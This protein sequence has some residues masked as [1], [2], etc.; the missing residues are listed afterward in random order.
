LN[1][2]EEMFVNE[3]ILQPKPTGMP[4]KTET[5]SI[6]QKEAQELSALS[7]GALESLGW[8]IKYAAK[9]AIVAYT[10]GNFKKHDTEIMVQAED[11]QIIVSS[12][13]IH[14]ELFDL[15]GKNKRRIN[16]FHKA[17]ENIRSTATEEKITEWRSKTELLQQETLKIAEEEAKQ[18]AEVDQVMNFSKSNLYVTYG[19]VAINIIVFVAMTINGVNL[20]EPRGLDIIKWGANYSPFTLSGDWWRLFS[21]VFVHIGI[22]HIVFNMY[23]LFMIGVYLEPMLGKARYIGA[24]FGTG[25]FASL[26]S[27]WWHDTPV[28]SA[29]A[30]G[31]IFG[32]YGV[33]LALL[34]T[35]L[36]P[37]Q[38]RNK[39]LQ[40][41]AIFVGYN[42]LYG[43]K[44]GVDNSAH[45]GGLISGLAIGYFYYSG[46]KGEAKRKTVFAAVALLAAVVVAFL[47]L[48]GNEKSGTERKEIEY[49]LKG[50]E[51]K[52]GQR[53]LEK[54]ESFIEMQNK[55][56]APLQDTSMTDE[57]LLKELDE[58][59]L[60]EWKKAGEVVNEIKG[61]DISEEYKRKISV[62]EEYVQKRIQQIG[63][64]KQTVTNK[65]AEN[66]NRLNEL[67]MKIN[68]LVDELNKL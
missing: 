2:S 11:Q 60:P 32:M 59:S 63:L 16:Q 56:L 47:Y 64:L 3:V 23:A 68:D 57:R 55:A 43:M 13:M 21:N 17:F 66:E 48:Q 39:L 8:N 50:M 1:E 36:I 7:Y 25:I 35:K 42:L 54:Y 12:K 52:D 45:I 22:I 67:T 10:P 58:I 9:N 20:F 38:V 15:T 26:T 5:I 27:L 51:H 6:F 40:S 53:F 33:F 31:A 46:W 65:T 41:I 24:Y 44:S 61:Y 19:I 4:K 37:Q 28:A 62:M 14:D 29:G 30:S 18:A 49:V 34:S